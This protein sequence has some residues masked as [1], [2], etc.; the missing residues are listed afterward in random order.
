MDEETL[1]I[2]GEAAMLDGTKDLLKDLSVLAERIGKVA[3]S[4]EG[5]AEND[6]IAGPVTLTDRQAETLRGEEANP[7]Q[8]GKTPLLGG[9]GRYAEPYVTVPRVV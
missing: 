6:K 8:D 2:L 3:S 1:A 4:R 7:A 5:R 9:S